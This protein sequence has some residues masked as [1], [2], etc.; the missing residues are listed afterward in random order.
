MQSGFH[1]AK[2]KMSAGLR[3]IWRLQRR[4]YFLA[5]SRFQRLASFLALWILSISKGSNGQSS[6]SHTTVLLISLFLLHLPHLKGPYDYIRSTQMIHSNFHLL[7]SSYSQIHSICK[8]N[9]PLPRKRTY[10]QVAGIRTWTSFGSHYS[11]Y[12][13]ISVKLVSSRI[14]L[15][16]Y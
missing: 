15:S 4:I 2:I 16:I 10:S 1:W 9:P 3:S 13:I 6:L 14:V 11:T 8:L 7:R 12:S 5:F